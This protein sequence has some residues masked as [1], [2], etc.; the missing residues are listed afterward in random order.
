MARLQLSLLGPPELT[1]DGQPVASLNGE[2]LDRPWFYHHDLVRGGKL[3][4]VLG[5]APNREWGSRPQ[6]A[7]PSMSTERP[8]SEKEV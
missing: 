2:P 6:D 3:K 1:L 7:P 5:P 8:Q 4:L